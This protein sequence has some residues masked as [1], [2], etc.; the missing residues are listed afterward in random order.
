MS[1]IQV[2]LN[3][4]N[5]NDAVAT[6][7][8]L[9][10]PQPTFRVT[11]ER[12]SEMPMGVPTPAQ[13]APAAPEAAVAPAAP[14]EPASAPP[15]QAEKRSRGR[16]RKTPREPVTI[17]G[18]VLDREVV[19]SGPETMAYSTVNDPKSWSPEPQPHVGAPPVAEPAT[20]PAAPAQTPVQEPY[21]TTGAGATPRSMLEAVY[22]RFGLG[23]VRDLLARFGCAR[24]SELPKDCEEEFMKLAANR[25]GDNPPVTF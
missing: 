20:A 13:D 16:P 25:L 9:T 18:Q 7:L 15:A 19:Q 22:D 1:K 2:T 4:D 3:F 11:P 24:I 6:L 8:T 12:P 10:L 5:V 21:A 23:E 17:D 14:A